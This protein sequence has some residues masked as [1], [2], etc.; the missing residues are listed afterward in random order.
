MGLKGETIKHDGVY[1]DI[2]HATEFVEET[3]QIKDPAILRTSYEDI[4]FV[5][6]DL[7]EETNTRHFKLS[8]KA[9]TRKKSKVVNTVKDLRD[10][11]EKTFVYN[12]DTDSVKVLPK[13][14][15]RRSSTG[16]SS[17]KRGLP[18]P[19]SR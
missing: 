6:V 12:D 8:K 13:P 16:T 10:S 7:D 19:L 17:H 15:S 9:L 11:A 5:K 2:E 18:H 1:K 4:V 14:K 3:M